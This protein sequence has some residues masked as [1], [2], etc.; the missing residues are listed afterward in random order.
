MTDQN[1]ETIAII[2][3]SS[4]TVQDMFAQVLTDRL[5][6]GVMERA[7]ERRV[8]ELI[9]K[10]ADEVFSSWS[11]VGKALKEAMTKSIMPQI[12][13]IDDLPVYHEF[14]MNRIKLAA[15]GFYDNRLTEVVDNELKAVFTEL[16]EQTTLSWLVKKVIEDAKEENERGEKITLIV[17]DR[18]SEWSWSKPGDSVMLYLDKDE[19]ESARDCQFELHLSKHKES[20]KYDILGIRVRG[21]KPGEALTVG[22]IYNLEKVLFNLYAMKGRIDLDKGLDADD[23]DTYYEREHDCQC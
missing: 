7:I 13:G 22:R 14:V 18:C 12:G 11:D 17:E 5:Q 19:D 9:A 4:T 10:T 20:G 16:P 8:D 2:D 3:P 1:Q 23:Y 21:R 15:Q 6:S